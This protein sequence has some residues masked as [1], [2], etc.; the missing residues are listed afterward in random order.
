M[1]SLSA[2]SISASAL[3]LA[4]S[5]I[6][7]ASNNVANAS[8]AGYSRQRVVVGDLVL[9]GGTG[10]AGVGVTAIRRSASEM[11]ERQRR[12][13]QTSYTQ[14]QT[15]ND[16][17]SSIDGLFGAPDEGIS[18]ALNNFYSSV[19]DL[20]R[21]PENRAYR[22][23]F[24]TALS[25]VKDIYNQLDAR[26]S[27]LRQNA[28][29][30]R[31]SVVKRIDQITSAL[32]ETNRGIELNIGAGHEA[33][34]VLL[35]Q[36]D[37]LLLELSQLTKVEVNVAETGQVNVKTPSGSSLVVGTGAVALS[38]SEIGAGGKLGA[39]DSLLRSDLAEVT[40]TA[41]GKL[42]SLASVSTVDK[43]EF[44]E[45][46]DS[47]GR[48]LYTRNLNLA[49]D[50][51]DLTAAERSNIV[52][53]N[54]F[55]KPAP[56]Q[57]PS[58]RVNLLTPQGYQIRGL[59]ISSDPLGGPNI[60]TK[61]NA[62]ARFDT[63][64][65]A[66]V[67]VETTLGGVTQS[68][69]AVTTTV[70]AVVADPTQ[71]PTYGKATQQFESQRLYVVRFA[72]PSVM[73]DAGNGFFEATANAGTPAIIED[74]ATQMGVDERTKAFQ[75]SSAWTRLR[76][77]FE[78]VERDVFR[79]FG[80]TVQKLAVSDLSELEMPD[81][82]TGI[83]DYQLIARAAAN[84]TAGRAQVESDMIQIT[85]EIG[86][87]KASNDAIVKTLGSMAQQ[88]DTE[89]SQVSG[90]NLDEEA[91]DLTRWQQAYAAASKVI[92]ITNQMFDDL[93]GALR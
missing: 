83:N 78:G 52:S 4:R 19:N 34:P 39:L 55:G 25:Q 30:E 89:R 57:D 24:T 41:S 33:A 44:F 64:S 37:S 2:L 82:A 23:G 10:S 81:A 76:G 74:P 79:A 72:N 46:V 58:L 47:N 92:A 66:V 14:A 17:L 50:Q 77:V 11:I 84:M 7:T 70:P 6:D 32:A 85:G 22:A 63:Q 51:N 15:T 36:R 60:L 56:T 45:V 12:T 38:K 18:Q 13:T 1:A 61:V 59:D 86:Q 16:Y 80:T 87:R 53:T 65:I 40:P 29:T 48:T 5:G 68:K 43:N 62:K 8:T 9:G 67:P 73:K 71:E 31:E 69:G 21:E 75:D 54:P 90:V 42:S 88:I 91:L 93:M 28:L 26:F 20:A 35:D 27:E 49:L 3:S